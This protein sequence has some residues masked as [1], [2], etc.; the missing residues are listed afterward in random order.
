MNNLITF[1]QGR[2]TY[3]TVAIAIL[4]V[5]GAYLGFW[6]LSDEVLAVFGLGALAFLRA[7][8]RKA[9]PEVSKAS[10]LALATAIVPLSLV[11]VGC[12]AIQPGNDPVVVNAERTTQL[13]VDVFDTFL[14]WEYD[15]RQSLSVTPEIRKA[16]D[17]IRAKGQDWLTTARSM[18][19]AYKANRTPENKANLDTAMAVLRM[20]VTEARHYLE[21]GVVSQ[22]PPST[23]H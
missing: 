20:A 2:K 18:T 4:Y 11:L 19:K 10:R 22:D 21:I 9:D 13:A 7:G 8:I 3:F 23:E 5:G 15:H 1:L 17:F 6:D 14:K 16:A 12:S